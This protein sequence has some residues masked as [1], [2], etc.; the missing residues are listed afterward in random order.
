[1]LKEY[2][3]GRTHY[4]ISNKFSGRSYITFD[5]IDDTAGV[6]DLVPDGLTKTYIYL[7][8]PDYVII[9]NL[10]LTRLDVY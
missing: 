5:R 3:H 8:I 1:M 6:G 4:N 2:H 9:R 10:M 7:V